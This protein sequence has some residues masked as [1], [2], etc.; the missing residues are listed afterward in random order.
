MS[1]SYIWLLIVKWLISGC[2][3]DS[4]KD[5]L[6]KNEELLEKDVLFLEYMLPLEVT[7]FSLCIESFSCRLWL[8]TFHF[9]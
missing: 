1:K 5:L 9:K 2:S 7:K 4:W 6:L 3:Y 8:I